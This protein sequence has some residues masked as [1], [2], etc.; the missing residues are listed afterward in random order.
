MRNETEIPLVYLIT[1]HCYGTWLHGDVRGSVDRHNNKYGTPRIPE[2]E[3]WNAASSANLKHPSVSLTAAMR[4]SVANAIKETCKF[5]EWELY[6]ANVRTNHAHA[7][8]DAGGINPSKVLLALKANA[9]RQMRKDVVWSGEHSPWTERGSKRYLW[10]DISVKA[11]V[12]Y[13]LYGQGDALP[14]FD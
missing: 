10:N 7:V 6:A 12:D 3:R 13:V 11:A 5:R 9:T 2:H 8:V 4:Y 1:F 14:D